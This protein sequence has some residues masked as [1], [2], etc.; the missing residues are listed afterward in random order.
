VQ[1]VGKKVSLPATFK[2]KLRLKKLFKKHGVS[3]SVDGLDKSQTAQLIN[4]HQ[5]WHKLTDEE[6]AK[7]LK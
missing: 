5:K 4:L 7:Y 6:K 1:I 2:Q 3:Q